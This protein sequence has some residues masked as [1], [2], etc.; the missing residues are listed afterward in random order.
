MNDELVYASKKRLL[1]SWYID[2][3]MFKPLSE[4]ILYSYD[5]DYSLP[6]WMLLIAFFVFRIFLIIVARSP[7]EY[8]LGIDTLSDKVELQ[9]YRRENWLTILV[10]MFLLMIG[11]S[12]STAWTKTSFV[13]PIF[14][15]VPE[16]PLFI[17]FSLGLGAL[18]ILSSI[19]IFRMKYTGFFLALAVIALRIYSDWK[20]WH[21]WPD[22]A[23]K[24]ALEAKA[25]MTIEIQQRHV[26]F[27]QNLFPQ[28]MIIFHSIIATALILTFFRFKPLVSNKTQLMKNSRLRG[29]S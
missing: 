25:D 19:L 20:S 27:L 9:I 8:M 14:G 2:F 6:S 26:E 5:P 29:L 10:A 7:S 1:L 16:R 11:I 3:L 21:L 18:Y 22:I 23:E 17:L 13:Y 24:M 12:L 4:M 28:D 15:F